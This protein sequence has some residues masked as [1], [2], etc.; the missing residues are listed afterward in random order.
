MLLIFTDLGHGGC[1]KDN[2]I[3]V[4]KYSLEEFT[5]FLMN[6]NYT[7]LGFL[8]YILIMTQFKHIKSI[9]FLT[10]TQRKKNIKLT[11]SW[12]K[13]PKLRGSCYA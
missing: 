13:I 11:W 4:P 8:F 6:M 10:T 9:F 2:N 1:E 7:F 5:F 3:T 12:L